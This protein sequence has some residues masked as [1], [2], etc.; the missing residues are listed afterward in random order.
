MLNRGMLNLFLLQSEKAQTRFFYFFCISMVLCLALPRA[1]SLVTIVFGILALPLVWQGLRAKK[2]APNIGLYALFLFFAYTLLSCFWAPDF[3]FSFKKCYKALLLLGLGFGFLHLSSCIFVPVKE[4]TKMTW[5]LVGALFLAICFLFIEYFFHYPIL[6]VFLQKDDGSLPIGIANEFLLNRN[7]VYISLFS[8]PVSLMVLKS[9]IAG[10]AKKIILALLF[11]S[12]FA[13]TAVA[14][15]QTSFI[16]LVAILTCTL[17]PVYKQRALKL[18]AI[19]FALLVLVAP[20]LPPL[21]YNTAINSEL[22]QDRSGWLGKA[23]AIQRLEVWNFMA[24]EIAQKPLF[25]HGFEA[26]RFLKS[27]AK[28]PVLGTD[29]IMHPHNF[30]L[31]LSLEFGLVG[32]VLA[33]LALYPL[34][35]KII[36]LDIFSRRYYATLCICTAGVLSVGYGLW[37]AWQIGMIFVLAAISVIATNID[38][39][40]HEK[41][42]SP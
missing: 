26:T 7:A 34:Y 39:S 30:A 28:M 21:L 5:F 12:L 37:Q 18:L 27:S 14:Q 9:D 1:L 22:F 11:L 8:L 41:T 17:L 4:F 31:Q 32:V 3:M 15:S 42:R 16:V 38:A 23:S 24:Q 36:S 2:F 25:G 33:L 6:K 40:R 19:A 20:M 10:S 35:Q 13:M 29:N